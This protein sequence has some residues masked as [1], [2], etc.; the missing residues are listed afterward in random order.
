[1]LKGQLTNIVENSG[2]KT[3]LDNAARVRA[4]VIKC[5]PQYHAFRGKM[6]G[7]GEFSTAAYTAV[8]LTISKFRSAPERTCRQ[9]FF[10]P[11]LELKINI[12]S[13]YR[14]ASYFANYVIGIAAEVPAKEVICPSAL[15]SFLGVSHPLFS[16]SLLSHPL[17]TR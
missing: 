14:C 10:S 3:N 9:T 11:P 1:M 6:F 4:R 8:K 12:L 17:P 2:I 5:T 15:A 16:P 7:P 13:R